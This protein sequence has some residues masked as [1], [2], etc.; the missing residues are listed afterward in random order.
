MCHV[1]WI[2]IWALGGPVSMQDAPHRMSVPQPAIQW[3][4]RKAA[5]RGETPRF[6]GCN[7]VVAV[8]GEDPEGVSW[9]ACY[10][11]ETEAA[12]RRGLRSDATQ[13]CRLSH[14]E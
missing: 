14:S 5:E 11:G 9:V 13:G 7:Y 1:A 2:L 3:A 6:V 4:T 12:V 10:A 8:P